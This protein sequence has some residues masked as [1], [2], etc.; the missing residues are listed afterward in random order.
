MLVCQSDA[1]SFRVGKSHG[2]IATVSRKAQKI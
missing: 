1:L 2:M